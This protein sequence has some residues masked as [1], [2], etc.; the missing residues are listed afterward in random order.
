MFLSGA[1]LAQSTMTPTTS[2]FR[3]FAGSLLGYWIT[4]PLQSPL[5]S[6]LHIKVIGAMRP[7][8]SF[9]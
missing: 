8:L 9:S 6:G 3:L 2:S 4:K 7:L 5:E 1:L